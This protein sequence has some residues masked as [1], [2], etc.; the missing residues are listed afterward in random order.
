MNPPQL[1]RVTTIAKAREWLEY[2]FELFHDLDI[3]L[4]EFRKQLWRADILGNNSADRV[5]E[6]FTAAAEDWSIPETHAAFCVKQGFYHVAAAIYG[7]AVRLTSTSSKIEGIFQTELT[8]PN[9]YG[10]LLPVQRLC[11]QNGEMSSA[12]FWSNE[13]DTERQVLMLYNSDTVG[14]LPPFL[15]SARF[16]LQQSWPSKDRGLLMMH[17]DGGLYISANNSNKSVSGTKM[18]SLLFT[19]EDASDIKSYIENNAVARPDTWEIA[20]RRM[21]NGAQIESL[22][23]FFAIQKFAL[24]TLPIED[25]LA[26]LMQTTFL[27]NA[28]LHAYLHM[29][30]AEEGRWLGNTVPEQHAR[31]NEYWLEKLLPVTAVINLSMPALDDLGRMR[32]TAAELLVAEE[33]WTVL[34]RASLELFVNFVGKR[35]AVQCL[36]VP[37]RYKRGAFAYVHLCMEAA[38]SDAYRR[39][40]A[41]KFLDTLKENAAM[42]VY[43]RRRRHVRYYSRLTTYMGAWA[44]DFKRG[45]PRRQWWRALQLIGSHSYDFACRLVEFF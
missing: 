31:L 37:D 25:P 16:P 44:G 2:Y 42:P 43:D 6:L 40:A 9:I 24:K 39:A 1:S 30:I 38:P 29:R 12:M 10:H 45:T 8:A 15:Y 19:K 21:S 32:K 34:P 36:R 35:L 7:Q 3:V 41:D 13:M 17:I 18:S 5:L 23:Y 26:L 33:P 20:I 11:W 22:G 4:A 28:P 27:P 14:A